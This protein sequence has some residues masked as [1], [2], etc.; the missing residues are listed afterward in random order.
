MNKRRNDRLPQKNK[1]RITV[2][3]AKR[4]LQI[5]MAAWSESA[6][7]PNNE[8]SFLL[9]KNLSTQDWAFT[10]NEIITLDEK[11]AL[12]V[13]CDGMGGMNAGEVASAIAV[14]TVKKWF[15]SNRLTEEITATPQTILDYIKQ[16]IIA[17]DKEIKEAAADDEEKAG[18]GSTIVLAWL[19]GKSVYVGWCGDS[20]AYRYNPAWGLERLSH[21]HSYVQE[22]V[23]AGKLPPEM[24]N[25]HPQSNIITRSLGDSGKKAEP[26]AKYF[27]LCTNDIILL[28]SDGLCGIMHDYEIELLIAQNA[29]DMGAC[30]YALLAASE[31]KGWTD[32]VTI[33]L[34]RIVAGG[35]KAIKNVKQNE[36]IPKNKHKKIVWLL[37]IV[38]ALAIG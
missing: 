4:N 31:E 29:K 9:S 19:T 14:E 15:A 3:E 17:A 36:S 24:A 11:G 6:G 23:D 37:G 1:M 30:R 7:R 20:R 33:A 13:V 21:D 25:G 16:T 28:C 18:M 27:P 26:D 38:A 10:T 8:D 2:G 22:L 34:C 12:L 35:G 32:N 5:S